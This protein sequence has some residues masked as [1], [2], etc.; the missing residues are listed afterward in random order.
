MYNLGSQNYHEGIR[1]RIGLKKNQELLARHVL[2]DVPGAKQVIDR[3]FNGEQRHIEPVHEY[4]KVKNV[5][6]DHAFNDR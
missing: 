6:L 1:P 4:P 5:I 3:V 2:K